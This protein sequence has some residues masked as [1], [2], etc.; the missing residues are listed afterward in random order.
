[1]F[2]PGL[3]GEPGLP[4]Q[5]G[6]R[7]RRL[8]RII[9]WLMRL[10]FY[11]IY[12]PMAWIY[13]LVAWSVSLGRWK[14]WV[15]S[16]LPYLD[17]QPVLELGHGPGYLQIALAERGV[18][19]FGLDFSRQMGR[20]ARRRLEKL[21]YAQHI[22]RGRSQAL[23]F[24]SAAFSR[25]VATFPSDYIFHPA[26]LAEAHRILAP[27]GRLVLAP[28]AWI[29]GKSILDRA[30]RWLFHITGEAPEWNEQWLQPFQD[31]GFVLRQQQFIELH[32]S[33]VLVLVFDVSFNLR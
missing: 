17:G 15:L 10:F 31:A 23:P 1:M 32:G 4:R 33:R 29:T 20:L 21:G 25:L 13:D 14:D 24:R 28:L 27:G 11:L 22:A 3:A 18:K 6:Q 26:T 8:S 9:G 30:A 2:S 16:V 12:Q 5:H 7:Q 19:A